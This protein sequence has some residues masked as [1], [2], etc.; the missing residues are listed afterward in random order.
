LNVLLRGT[1]HAKTKPAQR[2]DQGGL[3][4]SGRGDGNRSKIS[5]ATAGSGGFVN[6]RWNVEKEGPGIGS[7]TK[8]KK[9]KKNIQPKKGTRTSEQ[10]KLKKSRHIEKKRGGGGGVKTK[11]CD[12]N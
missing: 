11:G 1:P 9:A 8:E 7:K 10:Q 3:V 5:K 4:A 2:G 6:R 12:S